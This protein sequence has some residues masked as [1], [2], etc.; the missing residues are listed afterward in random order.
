MKRACYGRPNGPLVTPEEFIQ[1]ATPRYKDLGISPYCPACDEVVD[2]Y[3]VHSPNVTS[4]FDHKNFDQAADPLDDC[5]LANRTSRFQGLEP[6]G[7]DEEAGMRLRKEFFGDDNL[8]QA[9]AFCLAL[10]RKGNL[11]TK[12]FRSMIRRADRKK[13]WFYVDIRLWV[14]PFILLTLENFARPMLNG[15]P[16]YSFHFVLDKPKGTTISA[17]WR[18]PSDCQLKKVFSD[19]GIPVKTDDNPFPLSEEALAEKAG[20]FAWVKSREKLMR[21]LKACEK[22]LVGNSR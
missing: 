11:P 8:A 7:W 20:D 6:D 19:S 4:R 21:D 17:L 15:V 13:I 5:V 2:L 12:T 16:G 1:N 22:E 3:G 14:I 10:C 9:Y 18:S